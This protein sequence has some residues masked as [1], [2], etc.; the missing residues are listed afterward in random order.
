M[1]TPGR[2]RAWLLPRVLRALPST[3]PCVSM[4]LRGS[5]FLCLCYRASLHV[6][7]CAR[8]SGWGVCVSDTGFSLHV[9]LCVGLGVCGCV[10]DVLTPGLSGTV[11]PPFL[12]GAGTGCMD[13]GTEQGC[14]RG[15]GTGSEGCEGPG[16]RARRPLQQGQRDPGA[17]HFSSGLSR[18]DA[19]SLAQRPRGRLS[20]G[21]PGAVGGRPCTR[22]SP[23]ARRAGGSGGIWGKGDPWQGAGLSKSRGWSG[24]GDS[25][26]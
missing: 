26:H 7:L 5:L 24:G 22:A 1:H 25:I 10:G 14:R 21:A 2:P 15:R 12:L 6:H 17:P 19:G 20:A 3:G 9:N 8:L 4:W 11:R 16:G 13:G 18:S 23:L